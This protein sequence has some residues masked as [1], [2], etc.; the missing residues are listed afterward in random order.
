MMRDYLVRFVAL[1]FLLASGMA[2]MAQIQFEVTATGEPIYDFPRA[3]ALPRAER[4]EYNHAY[5]TAYTEWINS[6]G[7]KT[8][9]AVVKFDTPRQVTAPKRDNGT[10][11]YDD[12]VV[13]GGATTPTSFCH[14]NHFNTAIG[15]PVMSNGSVT[16]L[17]FYMVGV[18]G[19][20]FVSVFGP[21]NGTSGPQLIST[22]VSG[23]AG[24]QFNNFAFTAPINYTGDNFLA[25]VWLDGGGADQ[26]GFGGGTNAAQ[27]FHGAVIDDNFPTGTGISFALVPSVNYLVR[28]S[29]NVVTP[30]E[31]INFEIE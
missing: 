7:T 20:A 6:K 29:G 3:R 23:L 25:G 15:G 27:G 18:S 10:I 17:D 1:A 9:P 19:G 24:G 21:I 11:Q 13:A 30:V 8:A 16:Q 5:K 26:V 28:A 22:N 14:G 12:G 31:L 2:V 4:T